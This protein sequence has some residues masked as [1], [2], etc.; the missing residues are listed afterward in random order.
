MKKFRETIL[1]DNSKGNSNSRS[2]D[3]ALTLINQRDKMEY[4]VAKKRKIKDKQE[5][6]NWLNWTCNG[7]AMKTIVG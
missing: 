2:S 1:K 6:K 3:M 4:C 7:A 5:I